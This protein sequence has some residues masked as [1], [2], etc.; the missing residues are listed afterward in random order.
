MHGTYSVLYAYWFSDL[1][2]DV[3]KIENSIQLGTAYILKNI[4][5]LGTGG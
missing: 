2:D 4:I 3:L 1:R 5:R